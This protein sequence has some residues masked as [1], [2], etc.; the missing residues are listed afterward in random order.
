MQPARRAFLKKAA[1]S[2]PMLIVLGNLTLPR[3]LYADGTGGPPGPP[4][5]FFNSGSSSRSLKRK[6]SKKRLNF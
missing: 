3:P 5:G 6:R 2:T 1:Y 4:G